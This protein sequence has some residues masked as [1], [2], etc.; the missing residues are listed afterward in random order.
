MPTYNYRCTNPDCLHEAERFHGI[1][2][3][4]D[5]TCPHCEYPMKKLMSAPDF[6][7]ENPRGT[8]GIT[9]GD[10]RKEKAT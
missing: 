8:F 3:H 7:F 4:A 5:L 1:N 9:H 2:H 6:R 10:G